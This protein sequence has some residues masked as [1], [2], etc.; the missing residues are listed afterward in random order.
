MQNVVDVEED[1]EFMDKTMEELL[2]L[3]ADDSFAIAGCISTT[4]LS[5]SLVVELD[6]AIAGK[7]GAFSF[8]VELRIGAPKE[9]KRLHVLDQLPSGMGMDDPGAVTSV[10]R[11]IQNN[12]EYEHLIITTLDHGAGY[13]IF[14]EPAQG[15]GNAIVSAAS[16]GARLFKQP[17]HSLAHQVKPLKPA[18]LKG[19]QKKPGGRSLGAIKSLLAYSVKNALPSGITVDQLRQ[20][21]RATFGKAD[22]IFMRNCFMQMFDTGCTLCDVT[23]YLVTFESL[24]WF[25]E[26]NYVIWFRAMQAA[27]DRLTPEQVARSAVRGL[28]KAKTL[29]VF[30]DDT[31]LFG[32]DLSYYP[33]INDCLNRMIRELIFYV[34]EGHKGKLMECRKKVI[35][36][37]RRRNPQ[38]HYQLVDARLWFKTAG[39][40]L[41]RNTEYQEALNC[42][43]ALQEKSIARRRF[44][45]KEDS[46]PGYRESGF[47]LYFPTTLTDIGMVGSF[48]SL[49]YS[50]ESRN[51][52]RFT[53]YSLW[54]D[55]IAYLFLDIS[56]CLQKE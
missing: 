17:L 41:A 20:A 10:F 1:T 21:I 8:V 29:K 55:F 14:E 53:R 31:A 16:P 44:V 46:K 56:P 54:P 47:S 23:G 11:T 39:K 38:A 42:F 27:G 15:P 52:S 28:T 37:A 43:L 30:Q 2:E 7:E 5:Q 25:P 3:K 34:K 9:D 13:S 32:N 12:F 50:S 26:Y 51:L 49:Y 33:A 6:S 24:M 22:V 45:G 40:L 35:N 4:V 36:I 19:G 48:Y 18:K